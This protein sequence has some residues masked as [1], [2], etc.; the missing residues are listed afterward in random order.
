MFTQIARLFACKLSVEEKK[1]SERNIQ[2][3]YCPLIL[4]II[5]GSANANEHL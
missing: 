2:P 1:R 4:I 3:K 5:F